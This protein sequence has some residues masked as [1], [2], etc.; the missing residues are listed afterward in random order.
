MARFLS[1]I[2]SGIVVIYFVLAFNQFDRFKRF[3]IAWSQVLQCRG[4]TNNRNFVSSPGIGK[5]PTKETWNRERWIN[6]ASIWNIVVLDSSSES[7]IRSWSCSFFKSLY[8]KRFRLAFAGYHSS[9]DQS[10]QLSCVLHFA[11]LFVFLLNHLIFFFSG[12]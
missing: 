12:S 5:Q 6:H 4:A 1:R 3:S 7:A 10:S 2:S 11:Q 9:H 8:R